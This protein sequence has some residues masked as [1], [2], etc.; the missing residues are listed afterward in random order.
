M[1]FVTQEAR[2][3]TRKVIVATNIAESSI[4]IDEIVYVVD[5]GLVK[6]FVFNPQTCNDSLLVLPTTMSSAL[7]RASRAGR[8]KPGKCFRLYTEKEF[9]MNQAKEMF[10]IQKCDLTQTVLRLKSIGVENLLH[11]EYINTPTFVQLE[12]AL[13]SLYELGLLSEEG[14][15]NDRGRKVAELPLN[16]YHGAMIIKAQEFD[17]VEEVIMI[18]SMMLVESVFMEAGKK[19]KE[20]FS[21]EQGD[22]VSMIN[23]YQGF[24]DSR[25]SSGWCS[26]LSLDFRALNQVHSIHQEILKYLKQIEVH[27]SNCGSDIEKLQKCILS[28][29]HSHIAKLQPNGTYTSTKGHHNLH[30]HPSSVLYNTSPKWILYTQGILDSFSIGN[31]KAIHEEPHDI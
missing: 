10:E 21:V 18:I 28:V 14:K 16:V 3:K 17:C 6:M 11:F 27:V 9:Q 24:I 15:L 19:T 20:K 2:P 12:H 1:G 31:V 13:N 5:C 4:V 26:N 23:V 7:Q 30:I 8:S 29:Y 25:R 22:L